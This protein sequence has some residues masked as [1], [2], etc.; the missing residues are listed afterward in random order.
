MP[1]GERRDAVAA[2][3]IVGGMT[4]P[5]TARGRTLG[6]LTLISAESGR[7]FTTDD[8]AFAEDLGARAGLAV[9]NAM[10]LDRS[11][12]I[13]RT[14]QDSLLPAPPAGGRGPRRRRPLRRRR[15]GRRGRRRLLR[16]VPHRR[17]QRLGGRARRRLRQG[18]GGGGAHGARPPHPPRRVGMSC[19]RPRCSAGS[20]G[21]S[22][23]RA[24][25]PASSPPPTRGSA[26]STARWTSASPAAATR[27]RSSCRRDSSVETLCPAGPLLGI[28]DDIRFAES[29]FALRPGDT[30]VLFSDGV[31]EARSPDGELFGMD[32]V[33]RH[34]GRGGGGQGGGRGGGARVGDRALR[35]RRRERR[36]GAPRDPRA[37]RNVMKFQPVV[38]WGPLI[39]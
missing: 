3:G 37:G 19:R 14:L 11:R 6:V 32:R 18:D 23:G 5:L 36:P 17:R 20:T 10:L 38:R 22:C 9:D 31:I 27:P 7:R 21:R 24:P 16:P 34:R 30:L 15:R 35:R 1:P 2:L 39:V 26:R 12:E 33:T 28:M 29:G 25:T 4:V 13:A 8:L